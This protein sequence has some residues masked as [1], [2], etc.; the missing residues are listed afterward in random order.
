MGAAVF[1]ESSSELARLSNTFTVAGAPTD[2]TTVSLTVTTPSGVATTYTY[3]GS[4]VT[5]D[6][7]GVYHKDVTCSEAGDWQ[8]Q[9]TGTGAATDTTLGTFTVQEAALGKLYA[10]VDALKSRLGVS[11]TVDDYE[12]HAACFAASRALEQHCQRHFWRTAAGTVRTFVPDSLYVLH[13]PAFCDLVSV[14]AIA[15]DN[16]ADGT[17][18]TVWAASDY[19]LLPYNPAAAPEVKPYN[20]IRAVG[21]NPFPCTRAAAYGGWHRQRED[22][23]QVT[24]VWG[25]PTVPWSIRQAALILAQETFKA[26]DTFGGVAGFGEFGVVRLR[27]NPML[28]TYVDPYRR[29]GGFG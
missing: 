3:A 21:A 29:L 20:E 8:Y 22:S 14:S 23:V 1:Y 2:P 19:Q 11:D 7:A 16:G 25:W 9:W 17:Y 13:L 18:E 27:E 12:L 15:T 10:T 26:K 5:K 4:A 6:S 24:G 28:S